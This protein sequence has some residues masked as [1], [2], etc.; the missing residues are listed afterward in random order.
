MWRIRNRSV[1]IN[2]R[3]RGREK[4]GTDERAWMTKK[5][6]SPW[7]IQTF[8]QDN[9]VILHW[10]QMMEDKVCW[11]YLFIYCSET[12]RT[13]MTSNEIESWASSERNL[14]RFLSFSHN[15]KVKVKYFR[16]RP[17]ICNEYDECR[18]EMWSDSLK[19]LVLI[20][21][22]RSNSNLF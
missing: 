21:T 2:Q 22:Q 6:L 11:K 20:G 5:I 19:S 8:V 10:V 17:Y 18:F 13:H 14:N 12:D 4:G 15:N 9:T 3:E 16:E 1:I 7:N